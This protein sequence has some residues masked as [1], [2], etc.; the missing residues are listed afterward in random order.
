METL[1]L[2]DACRR[3]MAK[4]INIIMPYY[5]YSRQD[6]KDESRSPITSKLVAKKSTMP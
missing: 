5:P 4:T 1:I 3:S 2:I 6:K